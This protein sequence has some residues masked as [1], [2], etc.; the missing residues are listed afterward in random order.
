MQRRMY[1]ETCL[2]SNGGGCNVRRKSLVN[3]QRIVSIAFVI[4]A[5][6]RDIGSS[7]WL[8]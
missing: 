1:V 3:V 8:R 5:L 2:Y 6:L 4:S 7:N